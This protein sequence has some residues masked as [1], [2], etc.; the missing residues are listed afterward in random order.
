MNIFENIRRIAVFMIAAQTAMHF[1]AGKQYEKYMKVITSVIILLMF[2][3]PFLSAPQSLAVNW[4][5]EVERMENQLKNSVERGMPYAANSVE[6][7][8]LRQIEEELKVRLND[9][10]SDKNFT[11]EDVSIDLE[12]TDGSISAETGGKEQE[13]VFSRVK[14]T[15]QSEGDS[16]FA[17][18]YDRGIIAI[19]EIKIDYES[20][21]EAGQEGQNSGQDAKTQEYRYIFAQMLGIAEDRVEV[22]YRGRR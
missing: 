19:D 8:V 3:G 22:M 7:T 14:V 6:K 15:L 4:Q 13:W 21:N 18:T 1:A 5:E 9:A 17:D 16:S 2:I 20:V 12:K 11:V 10:I